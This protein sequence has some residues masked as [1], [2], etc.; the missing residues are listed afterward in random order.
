MTINLITK[1]QKSF[2]TFGDLYNKTYDELL[3]IRG[4]G[5]KAVEALL[6]MLSV[7]HMDSFSSLIQKF[8][9]NYSIETISKLDH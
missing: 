8:E 9:S 2:H 6:K 3:Q 1:L 7:I 4:L 5:K